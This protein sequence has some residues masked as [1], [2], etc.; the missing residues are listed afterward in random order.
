MLKLDAKMFLEKNRIVLKSEYH[1]DI[2]K[3]CRFL[4]EKKMAK[5]NASKKRW[6][7]P[8]K[9]EIIERFKPL[10]IEIDEKL[11]KYFH[12]LKEEREAKLKAK[13]QEIELKT[14][15]KNILHPYQRIGVGFLKVAKRAILAD[16]MGLGKTLQTIALIDEANL[17]KILIV[18]P[19]SL[20]YVWL[21][22]INKW[23]LPKKAIIIDKL[24][25]RHPPEFYNKYDVWIINY[26]KIIIERYYNLLLSR[27]YDLLVFDE[28]HNL[29]NRKSKRSEAANILSKKAD[30]LIEI[31]GTP[32]MNR[33]SELWH[34]LHLLYPNEYKSYWKFVDRYAYVTRNYFGGYE[35]YGVKNEKKLRKELAPILIRRLKTE[36]LKELPEKTIEQIYLDL[37]PKQQKYYNA[38]E[39]EMSIEL[40][41][42]E[43][44]DAPTVLAKI[45]RLKQIAVTPKLLDTSLEFDNAKYDFVLDILNGTNDKVVIFSQFAKAIKLFAK[46]L[47]A[48]GYKVVK[49]IGEMSPEERDK[50]ITQFQSDDET[51]VFLATLQAGGVG[52]TLTSANIAIFLDKHWTPAI[53]EQ[54]QDRLHRIGQKKNVLIYEL[55][56]KNTIEEYIEQLLE[57]KKDIIQAILEK[58]KK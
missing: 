5:W 24:N 22:E 19:N 57:G 43:S 7:F 13:E 56:A 1:S 28:A 14:Y 48:A 55:I 36:V 29:K 20:K 50:A 40:A 8:L 3:I 54:A 35:V 51:R 53:N 37:K 31:T 45:I 33:T 30:Y 52:I 9:E 2:L 38:M 42:D 41:N 11:S 39:E 49:Y 17:S 6:E 34:L 15:L 10:E 18:C 26:E 27:N 16:D 47:N 46:E 23:K 21:N 44:L 32:I 4:K 58:Y 12:K 25:Q